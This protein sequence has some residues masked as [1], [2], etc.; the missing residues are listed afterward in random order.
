MSGTEVVVR[1]AVEP[2]SR[3]HSIER[4]EAELPLLIQARDT[5]T[6]NQWLTEGKA[7]SIAA[8]E[9]KL[10]AEAV[11]L[12]RATM[13]C[14]ASLG[15]IS[16]ETQVSPSDSADGMR[17]ALGAALLRGRLEQ[18]LDAAGPTLSQQRVACTARR[19][20]MTYVSGGVLRK[21]IGS[22]VASRGT[23]LSALEREVGI[24]LK[25]W[26]YKTTT[27]HEWWAAWR[28][29]RALEF[30]I[31]KLPPKPSVAKRRT[32]TKV[33]WLTHR[34]PV[35][36]GSWAKAQVGWYKF[37]DE[38]RKVA[39]AL[40]TDHRLLYEAM[41]TVSDIIQREIRAAEK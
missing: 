6:I 2:G 14:V 33:K 36:D 8:R 38:V 16:G 41:H 13:H 19:L 10:L 37:R 20:G 7:A 18:V 23:T 1:D 30:D 29:A 31:C 3:S 24:N 26:Q 15:V 9:M 40:G 21:R 35:G 28:V 27:R 22:S 34:Q 17:R 4:M 11:Q 39:P 32:P 12:A 25:T 5:E